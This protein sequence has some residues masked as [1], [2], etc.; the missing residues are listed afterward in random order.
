MTMKCRP[1]KW[2]L[3]A[4]LAALPLLAA[5]WLNTPSL[6]N[7]LADEAAAVLKSAGADWAD[8]EIDGRD[9]LLSGDAPGRNPIEAAAKAVGEISG[10]RRVDVSAVQVKLAEPTIDAVTTNNNRPEVRGTWPEGNAK[11]L[12]LILPERRYVLGTDKELTSDGKGNWVWFPAEPLKDGAYNIGI[13][14]SDGEGA[15]TKVEKPDAVTIDT[16]APPPA[17]FE[18]IAGE[19]SPQSISGAWAEGEASSLSISLAGKTHV[20]GSD[21]ALTSASGKWTLA[22]AEPL[23]TGVY[24]LIIEVGDKA[25]NLTKSTIAKAIII[26]K[27]ISPAAQTVDKYSGNDSTPLL[28]GTF[29]EAAATVLTV[30]IGG[31]TYTLGT[32]ANLTSDGQGHWKL[33]ISEPLKD[34][35]YD[36]V[37]IASDALGNSAKD[38]TV[39]EVE[40][41][42]TGPLAPTVNPGTALPLTGTFDPRDTRILRGTLAGQTYTL[43][44][45]AALTADGGNWSLA[46]QVELEPGVYDVVVEAVD[47]FGNASADATKDELV[48]REASVE[49]ELTAPT[50]DK[51]EA[52]AARP[53]VRG[54]W[55]QDVAAGLSVAVAGKSYVFGT[56]A[57]LTSAD[58]RWSLAIPVPLKD[59]V[60]DIVAEVTG[61]DGTK[62][63]DETRDELIVDAAGPAAPTVV[64][65]AGEASPSAIRGTWA[66]GNAVSLSVTFNGKTVRLG[67]DPGLST[68]RKGGWTLALS[69]ALPP[70]SYDVAV[71]TV[72]KRG[73]IASD[74]TKNEILIK[75]KE[76]VVILAAPTVDAQESLVDRPT[77]TG[78]WPQDVAAGL[79]VTLAD[80][81][82]TLGQNAELTASNGRWTL[83]FPSPLKDGTYDVAAEVTG[84]DGAKKRDET[85]DELIID[86]AGPAS[87]TV[88]LYSGTESPGA[89]SGTWAQGDAV[90][91][92]VMFNGKTA[93]LGQD[94]SLSSDSAGNWTLTLSETLAPGSYDVAVT[95]ADK[96]GRTASDLTKDEIL[97]KEKDAA[98][99]SAPTVDAQESLVD[100]PTI[101]GT[102]PQAAA[103]RLSVTLAGQAFTLGQNAELTAGNGRWSL[104]FPSSLND[105]IYDVIAE[106]TSADGAKKQ[107]ETKD[108]LIVDA[109]GPAQPTIT[110]YS[111]ETSPPAISGTWAEG[112]AVTLSVTLNNKTAA[113]GRDDSLTSDGK[114]NWSLSLDDALASGRYDVIVMT[115][116]KHGRIATDATENEIVISGGGETDTALQAPTVDRLESLVARP[117][118]TGT[119]LQDIVDGLSVTLAGKT[120]VFGTDAEL[121]SAGGRWSLAVPS[122]LKDGVYDVAAEVTGKGGEKKQDETKDELIVDAAGPAVPTVS[123]YSGTESPAAIS[124]SWAEGDAVSLKVTF[125]GRTAEFGKDAALRSDGQGRWSLAVA[126]KL[127]PGSYDVAVVTADRRGR[128]ASDQTRFE[129]LVKETTEPPPPPDCDTEFMTTLIT[130][131]IHFEPDKSAVTSE[132][133]AIVKDL[134]VIAGSCK[135]KRLEVGGHT[136]STGSDAY[137][138]ALSERRA[139]AVVNALVSFGVERARL[140]A[141]GYGET[142]PLASNETPEGRFVNR[143]IEIKTIK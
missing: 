122:P 72:D 21:S 84:A 108:E 39:A 9:A 1:S 133:A 94:A 4:P 136:D 117:T 47:A 74:Q 58:G 127:A 66:E 129:I 56:D 104:A 96:H 62:K 52:L 70:G 45:D 78:T 118:V 141:K 114:G 17:T 143:R 125:N 23:A 79:S 11:T 128:V 88:A 68:D 91:L 63:Q 132:A 123:L 16:V 139:V 82:F 113:L 26:A 99:L 109:A 115:A 40:I 12:A 101:G 55:Q 41:D 51:I 19:V 110:S 20:L 65:Y 53:T 86:A 98:V 76:A 7:K 15:V 10:I 27:A 31:K 71:L 25:G 121:T 134:A 81:T 29:D 35:I 37:V 14:V 18:P 90:S 80:Q 126:E 106:V 13:E 34:G 103:T 85:K 120:Y 131:P 57:E 89:I 3:W 100:R 92:K 22:I 67:H 111:G 124:G 75:E 50:I 8:V 48:I 116:D 30:A 140:E 119:W 135:D 5:W 2:I 49:P 97:I 36:A 44:K 138:Q 73:R 69:E 95:T 93:Q 59:G 87:P 24:D 137:N 142:M 43:G 28:S 33:A 130:R 46:P 38:G 102:W 112:D 61:K 42:A 6:E 60:Y 107:D 54:G 77:I 105:G 64:L 83:A 32:D